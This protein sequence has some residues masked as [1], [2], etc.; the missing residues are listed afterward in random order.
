MYTSF[1]KCEGT[2]WHL[3]KCCSNQNICVYKSIYRLALNNKLIKVMESKFNIYF[4]LLT[5]VGGRGGVK[6]CSRII[7]LFLKSYLAC[8]STSSSLIVVQ[9]YTVHLFQDVRE[10]W[11]FHLIVSYHVP[12]TTY[13]AYVNWNNGVKDVIHILV[14]TGN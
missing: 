5:R 8:F 14:C 4:E 10:M 12:V 2:Y 11:S 6:V 3:K 9:V 1:W 7:I 13:T